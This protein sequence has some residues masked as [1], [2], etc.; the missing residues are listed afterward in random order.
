M[1]LRRFYIAAAWFVFLACFAQTPVFAKDQ[2]LKIESKNF[3]LYGNASEKDIRGAATRLEQFRDAFQQIFPNLKYNS[4]IPTIVIVFKDDESFSNFKPVDAD[5]KRSDWAGGYFQSGEDVNYIALS[6]EGDEAETYRTIYHEYIH[7][8]VNNDLGLSNIP[9]WFSEGIAEYYE[10][11]T[12]ENDQK[13]TLGAINKDNLELLRQNKLIPFET[14]FSIDNYSLNKQGTDGVGLFYAQAWALTHFLIHDNNGARNPQ[15]SKF[16]NLL[17]SGEQSKAAFAEAFQTDYAALEIQL[18]KYIEQRVFKT[19]IVNLK[20]KLTNAVDLKIAPVSDAEAK[21]T[22]GDLLYHSERVAEAEAILKEAVALDPSSPNANAVLGVVKAARKNFVEAKKYLEKAIALDNKNYLNYYRYAYALSRQGMTEFGFVSD[23]MAENAV[24]MREA[25]DKA[26]ALNP[27]FPESYSLYAF[28]NYVRDEDIDE[29]VE[30]LNKAIAAAPGDQWYQV[31]LAELYLRREDFRKAR[32][33]A[34][35]VSETAPDEHLRVYADNTLSQINS[36]EAQLESIKN[37]KSV[38]TDVT[39]KILTEEE[40]KRLNEKA[41]LEAIN[42]SLRRPK[43]DEKRVL[44]YLS[45]IECG[46]VVEYTVKIDDKT[47]KLSSENFDA[48]FLMTYSADSTV[49]ELGCGTIKKDVLAVITYRPK[50]DKQTRYDGEMI[51]VE[52]VPK[53]FKWL[54]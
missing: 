30:Y 50:L 12:I 34:R 3:Q 48:L 26:I 13:V 44:G 38:P 17:L 49:G 29:A 39:D 23:Y 7:S 2:W 15:L 46:K 5:G 41:M 21:A 11:L 18:K 52:L 8:L 27:N 10:Q 20:N 42:Q 6:I 40:I 28:I 22:L 1:K 54:N 4:A 35:K 33:I 25:L 36:Y 53:N 51:A 14:F 47:F 45:K 9:A 32:Q 24:K 19:Q 31:R 16:L 37:H 43:A